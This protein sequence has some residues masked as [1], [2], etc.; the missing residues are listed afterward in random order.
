MSRKTGRICRTRFFRF[1]SRA[2][3][4]K[5]RFNKTDTCYWIRKV[6]FH[7]ED[8]RTYSVHIQ[9][10]NQR[11]RIG[12]KT[13]DKEQAGA[14][15]LEFYLKLRALGWEEALRW[16]KGDSTAAKKSDVT[17]GE[18]IDA[19]AARSLFS[20]KTLQSYAQ[21]LPRSPATLPERPSASSAMLSNCAH[22]RQRRSK[23]GALNSSA[24]G[25]PIP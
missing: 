20:P 10:D 4:M 15:A 8:S 2:N 24:R 5:L 16:W 11:R 7:T 14:L 18:Y 12:L 17:V 13:T 21:A 3:S 6:S 1:E 19:V 22:S 25:Q 9:H 23:P